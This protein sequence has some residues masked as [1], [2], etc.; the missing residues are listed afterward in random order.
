MVHYDD[1]MRD[2]GSMKTAKE[3]GH[4]RLEGKDYVVRDGD[5]IEFRFN[6]SK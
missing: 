6:V 4:V 1:L 5:I 3:H 2:N